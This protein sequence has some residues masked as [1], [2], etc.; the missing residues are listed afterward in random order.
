MVPTSI[1]TPARA[2]RT[3][4]DS[5]AGPP[6]LDPIEFG[7]VTKKR[8]LGKRYEIDDVLETNAEDFVKSYIQK[9]GQ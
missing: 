3:T 7:P 2:R 1:A 8:V 5:A 4:T 9:G 6:I